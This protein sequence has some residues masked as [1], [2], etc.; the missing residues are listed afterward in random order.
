MDP[1]ASTALPQAV[2]FYVVVGM[3][4]IYDVNSGHDLQTI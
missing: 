4:D 2:H 1:I 3:H